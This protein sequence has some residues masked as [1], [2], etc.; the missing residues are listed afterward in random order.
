MFHTFACTSST[1]FCF[2]FL[3]PLALPHFPPLAPPL[4]LLLAL[5]LLSH[6]P[7]S[8]RS[9]KLLINFSRIRINTKRSTSIEFRKN[10][11]VRIYIYIYIHL[12]IYCIYLFFVRLTSRRASLP[13]KTASADRASVAQWGCPLFINLVHKNGSRKFKNPTGPLVHNF[14][15]ARLQRFFFRS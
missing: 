12:F 5:P 14:F 1:L 3:F 4:P 13:I 11:P 9:H 2:S 8:G 7:Y 10:C 15:Y 6:P